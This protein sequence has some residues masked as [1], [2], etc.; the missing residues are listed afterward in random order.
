MPN[1]NPDTVVNALLK[2][3]DLN[4]QSAQMRREV[5]AVLM[6]L[7][8]WAQPLLRN[9]QRLQVEVI[10]GRNDAWAYFPVD[11]SEVE[12]LRQVSEDEILKLA[13][14]AEENPEESWEDL[15]GLNRRLFLV[16]TVPGCR[17]H[18]E[19]VALNPTTRVLL[20]LG[21]QMF[22]GRY[23]DKEG[24]GAAGLRD[25]LGHALLYLRDPDARNECVDAEREWEEC[26]AGGEPKSRL[27]KSAKN[28][29]RSASTRLRR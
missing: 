18:R 8:P 17:I 29:A 16:G 9:E 28:R 14:M 13:E 20:T 25:H 23:R 11:Q 26:C 1:R 27:R 2:E 21:S 10:D 7:S 19:P 12:K 22:N 3:W 4:N 5:K 15:L 6:E 24:S